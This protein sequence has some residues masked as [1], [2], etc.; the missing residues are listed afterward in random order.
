MLAVFAIFLGGCASTSYLS[1]RRV[2]KNPLAGPLQLVSHT[3]PQPSQ[4][5]EDL[6]RRYDIL[7]TQ[8]EAPDQALVELQREMEAEPSMDK[9]YALAELSYVLGKREQAMGRRSEAL[10]LYGAAVASA[11]M[12]LFS[13]QFEQTRNAYDPQFRQACDLYNV[14][15]EDLLRIINKEGRLHP[16]ETYSLECGG[17]RFEVQIAARG[18]WHKDAFQEFEFVSDYDLRGLQNRHVSYGLGVP[19]IAVRRSD[20]T[21]DPATDF[22]PPGMSFPVTAILRAAEMP[23]LNPAEQHVVSCVLELHDPLAS[24]LVEVAGRTVP[25]ETDLTTPL[26]YFLD[27]PDYQLSDLAIWGLLKPGTVG[28][29]RGL[30]MLEA[31]D[32]NKIPVLMIHGLWSSPETWTEMYNEL[33]SLPEIRNRYQFWS[34]MYPT[35]QPFWTSAIQL[36]EDLQQMRETVDPERRASALDQM[37]LIGHSMGGLVARMQTLE[38]GDDFW[39]ILSDRPFEELQVEPEL[40]AKLASALFFKPNSSVRRVITLGTPHRGSTFAND[41]TRWLGRK[42]ITLPTTLVQTS[43][44]LAK[45]NPGFFHDTELLSITTSIDSLSPD[46]AMLA[47]ML[48]AQRPPWIRYHNV[49]G[50]VSEKKFLSRISEKG[51]GVVAFSSAHMDDVDSEI[52]VDADHVHVHQHP[53][54]I[55]E[56]RR[57]LLKHASEMYAEASPPAAIPAAFQFQDSLP[58]PPLVDE[59]FPYPLPAASG[60]SYPYPPPTVIGEPLT[61]QPLP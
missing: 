28:E 19:L 26:G 21:D 33:R 25:L 14:A 41:Y 49:V 6:L 53:R 51:D 4:R 43:A 8:K 15:L 61:D 30:Y 18:P 34:Y 3:G 10:K 57:I 9:R 23:C 60:E 31:F 55:L 56:V 37:V 42:L 1:V 27:N 35:G 7:E 12:Y 44:R 45:D 59:S 48:T 52:V 32:P 20:L 39:H 11:Y 46:S 29:Y 40:R 54:S 13:P 16:G 36:R 17:Q 38:S 5:T 22:Y 2:P 50:V 24:E 58:L 47:K